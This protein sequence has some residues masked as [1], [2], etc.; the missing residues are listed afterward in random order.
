MHG[1]AVKISA[2]VAEAVQDSFEGVANVG[3][4]IDLLGDVES[5]IFE[6][7]EACSLCDFIIT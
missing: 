4:H 6:F 5:H 1:F 3:F 7:H 2:V